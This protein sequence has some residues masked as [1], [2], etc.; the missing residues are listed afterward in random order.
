MT[1]RILVFAYGSVCY[2]VFLATFLYAVGFI[3]GFGVPTRLD[4]PSRGTLGVA[5]GVNLALL[6][7]FAVQHSVM[8]RPAFKRWWTRFVPHAVERTTYVLLASMTLVLLFWQWRPIPAQIWSLRSAAGQ[9]IA[10]SVF[11]G[12]FAIVLLSTFLIDHFDLFGVKQVWRQF[13]GRAAEAPRFATPLFYRCVRHPLYAGFILA[14][15]AC[16]AMSVGHLVFATAMTAYILIAIR[17]E[18]RDL[19]HHLGDS[20]RHYRRQVPMLVPRPW[21]RRTAVR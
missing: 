4:G 6:A 18:E 8:A 17:F 20:Y 10:W 21:R 5:L 11:C 19:L 9:A 7:L 14:F 13:T 1:K 2:L 3:G 16:P 12:G 15:W